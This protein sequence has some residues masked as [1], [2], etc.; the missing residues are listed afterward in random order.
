[1]R[2]QLKSAFRKFPVRW[3]F[4]VFILILCHS[5]N[6]ANKKSFHD[7]TISIEQN[8][9][10]SVRFDPSYYY[11]VDIKIHAL[12]EQLVHQWKEGGINAVYVKVYDPVYGAV[13]RTRY[14]HNIQ[15]DYGRLN[16][17]KSLIKTGHKHGIL[18]YAWIPAFQHK[19]AWE[20]HPEW[21]SKEADG[22]DYRPDENSYHLCVRN[23]DY[24]KWWIGFVEELLKRY[25]DLDGVDIAEPVVSWKPGLACHC[26]HCR[27]ALNRYADSTHTTRSSAFEFT[28]SAALTSLIEETCR[29]VHSCGKIVSVTSLTTAYSSGS[30]YSAREQQSSTGFDLVGI[31]DSDHKPDIL[32]MEILWQQWADFWNDTTIFQPEWTEQAV[33][34]V[35][36]QVDNRTKLVIHVEMTP[37]GNTRVPDSLFVRSICS[38]L[39][40]GAQGIDF[41]DSYQADNRGL[42]PR[43]KQTLDFIPVKKIVIFHDPGYFQDARQLEV[44]LRHFRTETELRRPKG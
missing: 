23:P 38:A 39:D 35:I 43:I 24:R 31:L 19:Q 33:R 14:P 5:F 26:G 16:L 28:R 34:N 29:L 8:R 32:N 11:D 22:R 12:C 27:E 21:R 13:Y 25:R 30:L 10:F 15:T 17:L 40:G 1:M 3:T 41:Y 37:I 7:R 36:S 20:A 6:C 2:N 9:F 18:I 4:F 42:W 44:L